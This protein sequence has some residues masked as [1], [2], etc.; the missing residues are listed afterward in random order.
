MCSDPLIQNPLHSYISKI[1]KA[2]VN[3]C[4]KETGVYMKEICLIILSALLI[5]C[6]T[7]GT[8]IDEN[9]LT[10]IKEGV[11]TKKE[12]IALLG[13]PFTVSLTSE[14]KTLMTYSYTKATAKGSSFIPIVGLFA[15]GSNVY[16]QTVQ[17]LIGKDEKVE[18][19]ISNNSKDSVNTGL[20]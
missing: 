13:P 12:V 10:Q 2:A 16:M 7:M 4:N 20:F 9:K 5:G 17:V 14:G 11:T 6:A 8:K 15:G 1:I 19:Y 3:V 18:K